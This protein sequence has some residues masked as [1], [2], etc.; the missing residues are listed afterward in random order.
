MTVESKEAT[1][2]PREIEEEK[3]ISTAW[4]WYTYTNKSS[5]YNWQ[6]FNIYKPLR[7]NIVW[8]IEWRQQTHQIH[9]NLML[10]DLPVSLMAHSFRVLSLWCNFARLL[11]KCLIT[12]QFV[13]FFLFL[14]AARYTL[15]L[16]Y[17]NKWI[18]VL[19]WNKIIIIL[20]GFSWIV[21]IINVI[22]FIW[23][24]FMS[25]FE[26]LRNALERFRSYV[27]RVELSL[28]TSSVQSIFLIL[29][30]W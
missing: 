21:N 15:H 3:K 23:T 16:F 1:T 8:M 24:I 2:I 10:K 19:S 11:S 4:N 28:L 17:S 6:L 26:E 12:F 7:N 5:Q 20:I 29:F 18:C 22:L 9:V 14:V 27:F 25:N 30:K 13:Y